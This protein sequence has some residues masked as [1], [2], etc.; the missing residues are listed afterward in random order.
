MANG[1]QCRNSQMADPNYRQIG[2]PSVIAD[3]QKYMVPIPPGGTLSDYVQFYFTPWS[4]MLYNI[5]TGYGGVEKVPKAD[6]V[7]LTSSLQTLAQRGVT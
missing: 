6:L 1:I 3:R 5:V 4:V 2:N 7:I